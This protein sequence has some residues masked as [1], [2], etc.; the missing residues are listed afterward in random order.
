MFSLISWFKPQTSSSNNRMQSPLELT[1]WIFMENQRENIFHKGCFKKTALIID[2][3]T[4][5]MKLNYTKRRVFLMRD[6]HCDMENIYICL[7]VFRPFNGCS[8]NT[9][10]LFQECFNVIIE[11]VIEVVRVFLEPFFS[12]EF[13]WVTK[14][15]SV[16]KSKPFLTGP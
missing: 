3:K 16:T 7:C 11:H 10:W 13:A 1:E 9:S 8:K 15:T 5:S 4:Q 12:I 14:M 2:S 6:H